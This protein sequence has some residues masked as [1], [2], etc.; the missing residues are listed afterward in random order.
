M[1]KR[2]KLEWPATWSDELGERVH[3]LIHAVSD[4]GGAI[5][6]MSPPPRAET[7]RWLHNVLDAVAAGDAALC[8]A[9]V[10]EPQLAAMGLWRRDEAHYFHHMAELA[11]IMA[12]PRTRGFGLGAVV[13]KALIDSA[14]TAGMETLQLGVRGNNHLAIELYEA[15]GFKVWGRLPNVIEVGDQR[16]DDVRMFLDLVRPAHL[17]LRGGSPS[18]PG[19]SQSRRERQR[20]GEAESSC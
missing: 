10:D 16:F 18:G 11:K 15:L 14:M 1:A 5:G 6:W 8:T 13:T 7:D 2:V 3:T 12:H 4:L 20:L 19:A 9:M 17:V